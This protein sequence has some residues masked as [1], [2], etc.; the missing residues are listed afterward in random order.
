GVPAGWHA[1]AALPHCLDAGSGVPRRLAQH[2]ARER[3]VA[4]RADISISR[5]RPIRPPGQLR[6]RSRDVRPA[7]R[8]R[9]FRAVHDIRVRACCNARPRKISLMPERYNM[10]FEWRNGSLAFTA[11][12]LQIQSVYMIEGLKGKE[13]W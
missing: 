13:G 5:T 9:N 2:R 11:R 10:N 6:R 3:A 8:A 12:P 7:A 4:R 1:R